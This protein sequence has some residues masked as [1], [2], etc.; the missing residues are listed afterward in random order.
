MDLNT[1][2]QKSS[3]SSTISNTLRKVPTLSLGSYINGTE[4]EKAEFVNGLFKGIKD[5]GFIILKDHGVDSQLLAKAYRLL[6]TFADLPVE[7][8][9]KYVSAAGGGQRGY[10]PFGKEHA[11]DSPVMDLKLT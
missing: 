4:A 9:M 5:Y 6:E 8:K 7:A 10:T 11:K 2:D 3:Q 1:S